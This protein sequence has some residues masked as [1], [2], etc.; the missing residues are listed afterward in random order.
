MAKT[1]KKAAK[2][3]SDRKPGLLASA[4]KLLARKKG[5]PMKCKDIVEELAKKK[6]WESPGGKTPEA[7][8]H[9]AIVTEIAK[10]GK[11]SRFKKVDKGLF[12]S[13]NGRS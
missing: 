3:A 6:M 7:T 8:L 4:A 13:A 11:E 12:A 9:A 2:P 1:E 10:K 5:K